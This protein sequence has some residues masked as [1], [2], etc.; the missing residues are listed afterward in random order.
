MATRTTK[1]PAAKTT[2]TKTVDDYIAA[3]PKE[4]RAALMK[5]RKT[6]T[7]A[8]PKATESLSY[9]IVGYKQN[10]ERLVYFGYWKAHYALYG[11]SGTF[12][13]AH[14]AELRPYVMSKGTIRFPA[15]KPLP[16][17]LV[18][19]IVKARLAEIEKTG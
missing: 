12:I 8:A 6:I 14:A 4:K 19:K 1:K 5:L 13:D 17:R 11:A 16:D 18:T 9:G 15:D 3:A 7:A 10:R 2:H